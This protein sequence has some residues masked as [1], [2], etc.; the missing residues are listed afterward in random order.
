MERILEPEVMDSEAEAL[1]YDQMDFTPVNHDFAHK[2]TAI[3]PSLSPAQILDIGTGTARIPILLAAERPTWQIIAIDLAPSMLAIAI[4]NI[5]QAGLKHQIQLAQIDGKQLPYSDRTF[6]G[7][8]SN[9][10]VHHL[11]N[12]L[13]FFQEVQR[14]V[15][16][17]GFI[18]IRDLLRPA[19][20]AQVDALVTAS[21]D[22]YSPHQKQ[23]YQD[24]LRAALTLPEVQA[25]IDRSGLSGVTLYPSSD[26]HWTI[27]RTYPPSSQA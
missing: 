14:V 2:S 22:D 6:D 16:P 17:E 5:E 20:A 4:K 13:P 12:P 18:L 21:G 10:L 26:R 11:P 9:S 19:T 23:L 3:A 8:I 27:E 7:V 24:S 1:E 25:L 15:K